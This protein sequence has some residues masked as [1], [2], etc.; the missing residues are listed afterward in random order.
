MHCNFESFTEENEFIVLNK[1][2]FNTNQIKESIVKDFKPR[3]GNLN[4]CCKNKLIKK[5]FREVNNQGI[6]NRIEWK[7]WLKEDIQCEL[8]A[9]DQIRRL[10]ELQIKII[11]DFSSQGNYNQEYIDLKVLLDFSLQEQ[12][13]EETFTQDNIETISFKNFYEQNTAYSHSFSSEKI[14]I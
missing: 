14:C 9:F 5:Y 3:K 8:I 2:V 1:I 12:E 6:Y 7:F 4:F 11:L 10:D 13:A